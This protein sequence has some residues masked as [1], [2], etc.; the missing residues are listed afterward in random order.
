MRSEHAIETRQATRSS[1]PAWKK[2]AALAYV[3]IGAIGVGLVVLGCRIV[4]A[5]PASLGYEALWIGPVALWVGI[6]I[7]GFAFLSLR[8]LDVRFDLSTARAIVLRVIMAAL[9]LAVGV[10]VVFGASDLIYGRASGS[11]AAVTKTTGSGSRPSV[12]L[13]TLKSDEQQLWYSGSSGSVLSIF[14][15]P[16]PKGSTPTVPLAGPDDTHRVVYVTGADD[17]MV[18]LSKQ[19][20]RYILYVESTGSWSAELLER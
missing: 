13:V 11:W 4:I 15:V 10:G 8:N 20:G 6:G 17:A 14:L 2:A 1:T 3:V 18:E 7:A 5:P 12:T 9:A 19:P 16:V